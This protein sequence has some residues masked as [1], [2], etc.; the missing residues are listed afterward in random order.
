MQMMT[1]SLVMRIMETVVNIH[2]I[3]RVNVILMLHQQALLVKENEADRGAGNNDSNAITVSTVVVCVGQT[4]GNSVENN[5]PQQVEQTSWYGFKAVGDNFDKNV[6]PSFCRL[7]KGTKSLHCFHYYA[8]LDRLDLS[9]LSDVTPNTPV[10]ANK[11]LINVNDVAQL[12]SDA[13]TLHKP[14]SL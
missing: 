12:N 13:V 11:L 1:L 3:Q 10:D 14:I 9:S 7:D 2:Q 5:E 4:A 6:H 8:V